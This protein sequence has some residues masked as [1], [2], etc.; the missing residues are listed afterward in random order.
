MNEY[1][2]RLLL[3][4]EDLE[5]TDEYVLTRFTEFDGGKIFISY[6]KGVKDADGDI[7]YFIKI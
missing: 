5:E 7:V 3:K 4:T 2:Q 6:E 1:G